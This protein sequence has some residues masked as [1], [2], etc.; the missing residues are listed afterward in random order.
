MSE[1]TTEQLINESLQWRY[2]TKRFD[3]AKTIAPATW[4]ALEESLRMAP[5]S[6]GLQPWQWIV[7]TNPEVRKQLQ[8][9]SWNQPQIV[10][11]SHLVVLAS[12]RDVTENEIDSFLK[13]T[14]D[15]RSVPL[16]SL[17]GYRGMIVPFVKHL[18]DSNTLE[19]WTTRQVYLALGMLLSSAAMLHVDAC[20]MEGINPSQY[21]AILGLDKTNFAT[22]VACTLGYRAS[23]DGSA[24]AAK[25]RYPHAQ[26][27][28]YR[29]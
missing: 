2:A 11:A 14:A 28:S 6:F 13:L 27:F 1:H 5:S 12:A 17:S 8:A 26:V 4:Q 9:H 7:V 16:E 24:S 23:T 18:K 29:S 10:E 25:I 15:T 21:D 19:A 22:R 3:P 20:P